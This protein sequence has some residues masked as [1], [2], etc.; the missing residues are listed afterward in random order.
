MTGTAS[1]PEGPSAPPP[2]ARRD[3]DA[4]AAVV[5]SFIGLFA[6]LVGAYTAYLQRQQLRAQVWPHL[7][8]ARYDEEAKLV[9][10]NTGTGPARIK[11]IRLTIDGQ[12]VRGWR[13][14]YA[15]AGYGDRLPVSKS[16]INLQVIPAGESWSFLF[17]AESDLGRQAFRE[18][19][20]GPKHK[21]RFLVCYCSVLD[22][23]WVERMGER[24][25]RAPPD[26]TP[27]DDCGIPD[28][29]QLDE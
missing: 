27:V 8:L 21:V 23:C 20:Y 2:R 29:Q 24:E 4:L 25:P 17:L 7:V 14:L 13:E 10:R 28:D 19:F 12:V 22:D 26:H 16:T 6:L 5:A 1:A 11:G 9:A 18:L 15:R 3:W